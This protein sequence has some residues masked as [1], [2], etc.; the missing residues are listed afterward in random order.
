MRKLLLNVIFIFGFLVCITAS[1]VSGEIIYV[2]G[3]ANGLNNGSSWE[4]AY[5]YLQDALADANSSGDVNE[6][7]LAQGIYTPDTNSAD[8]NG[9][10]DRTA[11]FQLI[12]NVAIRGGYAG[13]GAADPNARDIKLYETTL[14]GDLN[15]NDTSELDP[16][17]L[18]NDPNRDKNCCHVVAANEI[19]ANSILDGFRII[20][21]NANGSDQ[22][23]RGG[24]LYSYSSSPTLVN[25]IFLNNFAQSSGGGMY[26]YNGAPMLI[27]CSFLGNRTQ[28][29]TSLNGGGGLYASFCEL[30]LINCLFSGNFTGSDG[31]AIHSVSNSMKAINC[32]FSQNQAYN[33]GA[34]IYAEVGETEIKNCIFWGNTDDYGSGEW[35][36]IYPRHTALYVAY[37]CIQGWTWSIGGPDNIDLD[38]CFVD[39]NGLDDIP[40]TKDDDLKLWLASPCIDAGDN[41][42]VPAD[43]SDLDGDGNTVEPIPFDLDGNTRIKDGDCNGE[44]TV[45]MGAYE[46]PGHIYNITQDTIHS[47][48][49]EAI[50]N[51][52]SGDEIVL[53]PFVYTGDENRDITFALAANNITVRSAD[54][55]DPSVVE[56][57]V[58]DCEGTES[59]YHRAFNIGGHLFRDHIVSGITITNGYH[60]YGGAIQ[61]NFFTKVKNCKIVNNFAENYGGGI[62]GCGTVE[63]CTISGNSAFWGG[64]IYHANVIDNCVINGNSAG[65]FGGGVLDSSNLSNCTIKDNLAIWAG[66]GV[67]ING[68]ST[69]TNC[70]FNNNN[71]DYHGGGIYNTGDS[72]LKN[73]LFSNNTAGGHGGGMYNSDSNATLINCTFSNNFSDSGSVIYNTFSNLTLTNCILWDMDNAVQGG[74]EITLE[75]FSTLNIN[76][77]DVLNGY[78]GDGT[79]SVYYGPGNIGEDPL[80]VNDDNPDPNLRDY[81]L[82]WNSQC[83]DEGNPGS[84]LGDEPLSGPFPFD[85]LRINMGAYG[86]TNEATIGYSDWALL[87]DMTNDGICDNDDLAYFVDLWLDAGEEL[88]ADFNRDEKIDF[89]DFALLANDWLNKTIWY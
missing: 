21:G 50:D 66:G 42:S 23:D 12:G 77:C 5:N 59:D 18:F 56:S 10:G 49:Q 44:S 61:G 3:D 54:P 82:A 36:Q 43:I 31:G 87:S 47:T 15:G 22:N 24:G 32:T 34:G 57:T 48:I 37:S 29:Q 14:S 20:A 38:P 60:S 51:A 19:D 4:N 76:Y 68:I 55:N 9:T 8:P 67:A 26:A 35:S 25:C 6:I 45:D 65:G 46:H 13:Y 70:T 88:Y 84:P 79:E 27:N 80:F 71:A 53:S 73:C 74:W 40:G 78:D 1:S 86:G 75:L 7:W 62:K 52:V 64:G 2:D 28:N 41:N 89:A 83:I 85:N 16:C 30:D 33:A 72:A 17:D 81:H 11:T 39:V 63:N 58:I 69:L